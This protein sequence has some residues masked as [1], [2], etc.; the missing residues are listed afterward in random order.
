MTVHVKIFPIAEVSDEAQEMQVNLVNGHISEFF[1]FLNQRLGFDPYEKDL[2]LL[3]NGRGLDM[4]EDVDL[5][6]GDRLWLM[7]MLSGG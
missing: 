1:V 4:R 7:P 5:Q 2:M 3:H 6:D